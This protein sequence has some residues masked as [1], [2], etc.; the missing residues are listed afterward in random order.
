MKS[1]CLP[2]PAVMLIFLCH[3]SFPFP[4]LCSLVDYM[5]LLLLWTSYS[6]SPSYPLFTSVYIYGTDSMDCLSSDQHVSFS[7][8]LHFFF[9]PHLMCYEHVCTFLRAVFIWQQ[10]TLVLASSLLELVYQ[11]RQ[12]ILSLQY[13]YTSYNIRNGFPSQTTSSSDGHGFENPCGFHKM[14]KKSK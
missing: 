12:L 4:C 8:V 5:P 13:Q 2:P 10:I 11:T 7:I 6:Y 1:T 9:V 14:I 3:A